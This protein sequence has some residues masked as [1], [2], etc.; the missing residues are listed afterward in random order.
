MHTGYVDIQVNGY[1]GVDF[2]QNHL[3]LEQL[4]YACHKL[5]SDNVECILIALITAPLKDLAIR[6]RT[7]V[8]YRKQ[9][10]LVA[11]MVRGIHLEGPFISPLD[12]F[13]GAHPLDA[14]RS[15]D[16][17]TMQD[18]LA[19]GED[20]IRLVTLA[21]ELPG[22]LPLIEWLRN[23]QVVVAAGHCDPSLAQLESALDAGLSLFT[24]LGNGCPQWLHRHDN[25]IQRVL[26]LKN[27]LWVSFIADGIHIPIPALKN[28]LAL[29][30]LE[31]VIITTDAMAAAG[32]STGTFTLSD[33]ELDVGSDG[34]VVLPGTRQFAGSAISM[35]A[36]E[37][38]L[39]HQLGLSPS[40]IE[41]VTRTNPLK[42][43]GYQ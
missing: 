28:Y 43:L 26:S 34:V 21:P 29:V 24:H 12:G 19:L 18:L 9:S 1:A 4:E 7:I 31:R 10:S 32:A 30:G 23:H 38:I 20:T 27:R 41:R 37:L 36:S 22:A 11:A 35:P 2:N 25:I 5:R 3:T 14:I 40:D 39:A 13:R 15:P 17:G 42:A 16:L 8:S 6:V 33:L